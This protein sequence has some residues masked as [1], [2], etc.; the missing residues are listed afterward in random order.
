M[1][2]R[3]LAS[4]I[5]NNYNY[6]RF[7]AQAIDSALNQTYHHTE[8]LVVDD[9]STDDSRGII[10]EYGDRIVP[11]LKQNGGMGST[12]N[13]GFEKSRGEVILLLD[14]DDFLL[15]TAAERAAE[16]LSSP[17]VA[18]VHWPLT[19]VDENGKPAGGIIPGKELAEGDMQNRAIREGPD[20][21]L[22]P[23]TSGN[24]WS[25]R[26][27]EEVLPVPEDQYKQ[28][29]DAYLVTLASIHGPIK[30]IR[31][32][33]A[34]YRLH[35]QNDYACRPA[36]EKNRRNLVIYER[37]CAAL[38]AYLKSRGSDVEP[39]A[40]KTN[41][42]GY[43]WMRRLLEATE[44]IKSVIAAGCSYVLVDEDSWGDRWGGSELVS[45]RHN[46][47]FIEKNGQYWG[48]PPDDQTA[49]NELERL[50]QGGA[51]FIVFGWPAFWWLDYYSLFH[52]FL[53]SNYTCVLQTDHLVIFELLNLRIQDK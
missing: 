46:I 44:A 47:P 34:C 25:R 8:V 9:G 18:K 3:A 17:G 24:A 15:P 2:E 30:R 16:L 26:F 1:M 11:V 43:I 41:N 50:R 7:L 14:S 22:S 40:W 20:C 10:A 31:E 45:D 33:Q 4:I 12:Y 21:Y 51:S 6:G 53:R 49:I 28:H 32:P 35:G 13:A 52:R 42:S 37:R 39:D 27:L 23:P 38:S 36:D 48:P 19:V 5:V 29:A